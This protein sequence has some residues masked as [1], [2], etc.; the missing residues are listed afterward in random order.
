MIVFMFSMEGLSSDQDCHFDILT[1][2]LYILTQ[3]F[4]RWIIVFSMEDLR[5]DTFTL[6]LDILTQDFKRWM[7]VFMFSMEDLGWDQE[8]VVMN[9]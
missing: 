6:I 5:F 1:P 3:A 8:E 2:I 4:K 9:V 7:I